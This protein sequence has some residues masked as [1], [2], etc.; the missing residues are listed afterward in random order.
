MVKRETGKLHVTEKI[1]PLFADYGKGK[2]PETDANAFNQIQL[3]KLV[4]MCSENGTMSTQGRI[5]LH[6]AIL[7]F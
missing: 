7:Y 6:K 2:N 5:N 3:N 1:P 4:G